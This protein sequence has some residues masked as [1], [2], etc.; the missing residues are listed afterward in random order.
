MRCP[1]FLSLFILLALAG[2]AG[3]VNAQQPEPTTRQG[4]IEQAQAEKAKDL[5]PY[6]PTKARSGWRKGSKTS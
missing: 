4:V 2:T 1:G 3:V 6:V 5:H